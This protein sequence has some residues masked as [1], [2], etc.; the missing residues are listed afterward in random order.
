MPKLARL[1]KS[2]DF[3]RALRSRRCAATPHFAVHYLAD[4]PARRPS[5]PVAKELSTAAV[6]ESPEPVDDFPAGTSAHPGGAASPQLWLGAVVP[7]RHARRAVTRTLIKRQIRS[8]AERHGA[9]L[10]PGIWIVRLRAPFDRA[11]FPSAASEA[12]RV[13]ARAELERAMGAAAAAV[14]ATPVAA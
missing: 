2:I 7:K 4:V 11:T 8:V 10:R 3:E 13:T 12:L 1:V 5:R 9:D 6:D 14:A